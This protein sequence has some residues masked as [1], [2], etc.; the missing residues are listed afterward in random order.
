MKYSTSAL[1]LVLFIS[2]SMPLVYATETL[3]EQQLAKTVSPNT[4]ILTGEP[5]KPVISDRRIREQAFQDT[6]AYQVVRLE[7][8]LSQMI[9]SH[10]LGQSTK[11][12]SLVAQSSVDPYGVQWSGQLP[13]NDDLVL[14]NGYIYNEQTG[15]YEI[16]NVK[17]KVDIIVTTHTSDH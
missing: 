9:I 11:D 4:L 13:L 16:S 14:K 15:A 8:N 10:R 12:E 2:G 5:S 6:P 7:K 17:G 1:H 3:P